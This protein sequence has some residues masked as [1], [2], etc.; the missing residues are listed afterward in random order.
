MQNICHLSKLI[1]EQAK[2]YGERT[3]LRYRDYDVNQW[4]PISWNQFASKVK[5]VSYAL[6]RLGVK[7]QE[8]IAVFSQNKPETLFVDFGAYGIRVVSIP[9]YAT[10]SG[11][12][13]TYMLMTPRF[14]IS[15]WA[16]SCNTTWLSVCCR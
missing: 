15:L 5:K 1:F 2:R 4:I 9:F 7:P 16:N 11:A 3:A 8:N 13:V 12:L 6:L 14:A 10:S